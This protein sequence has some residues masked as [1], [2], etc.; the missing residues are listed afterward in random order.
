M[1]IHTTTSRGHSISYEDHGG[2]E[3]L[4]LVPG[5]GSP[6]REWRDR[7]YIEPLAARYRVLIV[8]PLGHGRSDVA[9]DPDEYR[10]PDVGEDVV[11]VLDAAGVESTRLWGYSRGSG[12][13]AIVATEHP[14]RVSAL[15]L[16]GFSLPSGEAN[17]DVSLDTTAMLR[18]DWEET[19]DVWAAD[20]FSLSES[21]RQYMVDHSHPVGIAASILGSRRSSHVPDLTEITC[22]VFAYWASADIEDDPEPAEICAK[23]GIEPVMLPGEHD[24]A[25]GFN[26][27]AAALPSVLEFLASDRIG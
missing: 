2:G 23:L 4:V 11:A 3:P 8:D 21:D 20:G 7:G 10:S 22:P 13:A 14:E 6:A 12:L 5:L 25:E 15:V 24:H 19:F 9:D 27:S 17:F 1:E 18:G 26:D 16:G